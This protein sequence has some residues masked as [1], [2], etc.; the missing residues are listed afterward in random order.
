MALQGVL[1]K[2]DTK[3]AP[4]GFEDV[5]ENELLASSVLGSVGIAARPHSLYIWIVI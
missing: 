4:S 1:G 5:D 3:G 2:E